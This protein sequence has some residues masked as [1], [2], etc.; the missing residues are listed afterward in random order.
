M[1]AITM[2]PTPLP[3]STPP[4]HARGPKPHSFTIREYRELSHTG[5]FNDKKTMLIY[6]E[7]YVMGM[8]SAPHDFALGAT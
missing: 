4:P 8:P 7:L 3:T 1:S 2:P 5:L 6:G